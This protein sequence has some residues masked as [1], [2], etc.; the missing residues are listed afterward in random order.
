ML[1]ASD[2]ASLASPNNQRIA[3]FN[4][5]MGRYARKAQ[6]TEFS[7][8]SWLSVHQAATVAAKLKTVNA[9][10]FAR[11]L[12]GLPVSLGVA[13]RF[14][15]GKGKFFLPFPR[16]FRGTVQFQVVKNGQ[17]MPEG[18]GAFTDL[19]ALAKR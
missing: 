14:T 6:K 3:Q 10:S 5:E 17:I 2:F 4:R 15:L 19:N 13:P 9:S 11:A 1:S 18:N 16:V 12:N 8:D 7:L